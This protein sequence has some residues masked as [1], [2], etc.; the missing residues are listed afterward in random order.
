MVRRGNAQYRLLILATHFDLSL[1]G[2][3]EPDNPK[4]QTNENIHIHNLEINPTP[5]PLYKKSK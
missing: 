4:T 5:L 1:K 3:A 2:P